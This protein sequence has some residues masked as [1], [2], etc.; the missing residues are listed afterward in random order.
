MDFLVGA[1]MGTEEVVFDRN[2]LCT[3]GD[4][5]GLGEAKGSAVVFEDCRVSDRFL[6]S[7]KFETLGDFFE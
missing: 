5:W 3:W 2:V 1:T 4:L 7:G 6:W